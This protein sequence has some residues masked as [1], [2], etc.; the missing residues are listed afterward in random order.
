MLAFSLGPLVMVAHGYLI[1]WNYFWYSVVERKLTTDTAL[2][3]DYVVQGINL[4]ESLVVTSPAW[5]ILVALAAITYRTWRPRTKTFACLWVLSSLLGMAIGGHW[6]RHY[7]V[8]LVPVLSFMAGPGV[9]HLLRSSPRLLSY[10]VLV[11]AIVVFGASDL[12]LWFS[13]PEAVSEQVY[14]RP[15]YVLNE[16]VAAYVNDHTAEDDTIYVAF[17]QAEIYYL[18]RRRNAVP[19]LF[20]YELAA[21]QDIY[22]QIV[23]SIARR[24]PAMIVWVQPPP[25]D[26][27]TPEQFEALLLEGYVEVRQFSAGDLATDDQHVI[28]VYTRMPKRAGTSIDSS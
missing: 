1:G 10:K 16:E 14:D 27:A 2:S 13:A 20:G 25:D 21:S 6:S 9:V 19:Q 5:L 22:E 12:P 4:I 26:Y 11:G 17:Y 24:E 15:G 23:V 7:Y 18:A 3:R 8:Q 28:R